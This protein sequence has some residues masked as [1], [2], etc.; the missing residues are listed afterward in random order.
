MNRN[1]LLIAAIT[2]FC[3]LAP[4]RNVCTAQRRSDTVFIKRVNVESYHA[5]FIDTNRNSQYYTELQNNLQSPFDS[6]FYFSNIA[7]LKENKVLF[8]KND[9]SGIPLD[10]KPLNY[11]NH[12]YYVYKPCD[13]IYSNWVRISDSTLLYYADGEMLVQTIN[14]VKHVGQ[15]KFSFTSTDIQGKAIRTNIYIL[16]E[17]AGMAVFE[18]PGKSYADRFEL[19]VASDKI[20][21]F[22]IIVNYSLEQKEEELAFDKPD[23]RRLLS[24]QVATNKK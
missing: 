20:R 2:T 21:N 11:Y 3:Y 19:R 13:G 22:P 6:A 24:G 15:N 12:K 17:Q 10:W 14:D 16:D 5:I 8:K 7:D 23:F 1:K 9:L 18:Y 4:C